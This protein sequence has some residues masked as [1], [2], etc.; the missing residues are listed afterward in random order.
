MNNILSEE[1]GTEE[2]QTPASPSRGHAAEEKPLSPEEGKAKKRRKLRK[3][4][5]RSS[6]GAW[7]TARRDAWHRELLSSSSEDESEDKYLRFKESGRWIAEIGGQCTEARP[8]AIDEM[9][10]EGMGE[11]KEQQQD[12][13]KKV[14]V[15]LD[16]LDER[17]EKIDMRLEQIEAQMVE[18]KKEEE[19]EEAEKR[20]EE[21]AGRKKEKKSRNKKKRKIQMGEDDLPRRSERLKQMS[22]G[23][24]KGAMLT[25]SLLSVLTPQ[26]KASEV[27][28]ADYEVLQGLLKGMAAGLELVDS[29]AVGVELMEIGRAGQR[30][31]R[32]LYLFKVLGVIYAPSHPD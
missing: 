10:S 31:Q 24:L 29:M 1:R 12:F 11:H 19:E 4:R 28:N 15:T 3:K 6:E 25:L 26:S 16:M 32:E 17:A 9:D 22:R 2:G 21:E 14:L 7:E 27:D 20:R 23:R 8:Q 18:L 13:V 5:I 30:K